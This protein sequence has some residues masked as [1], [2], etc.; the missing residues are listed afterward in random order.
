MSTKKTEKKFLS[1]KGRPLIRCG[2]TIYYGD[3]NDR[4]IVEMQIR[5]SYNLKGMALSEKILVLLVDS[6]MREDTNRKIIKMSEKS[7]LYN[8]LDVGSAWLDSAKEFQIH[9]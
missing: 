1:F 9:A 6:E 8:A 4:F 2:N 5:G 3:I 7:G